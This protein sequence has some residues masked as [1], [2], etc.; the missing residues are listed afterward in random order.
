MKKI[1]VVT[2]SHSGI[3]Q[4]L[5]EEMG[6]TVIP[7]PFYVEDKCYY[8]EISLTRKEFFEK[9]KAGVKVSTSQPAPAEVTDVW[10]KLLKEYETIIYIPISSGLSGGCATAMLLAQEEPYKGKVFVVDNGRASTP[11]QC[12]IIDALELIKE[13]YS[14]AEIK[15]M[16]EKVKADLV[17]YVGLDTLENLK[18]GGRISATSAVL[19][20]ILNIKPIVKFDIGTLDVYKKCRG[21]A[22]AKKEM[23][24][25]LKNDIETRFKEKYEKDEIYILAASSAEAEETEKWIKEIEEAFPGKKVLSGNLPMSLSCHIGYGG[26]GIGCSCKPDRIIK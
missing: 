3:S 9:L 25:A 4:K 14:A 11:Q 6:I 22:K 15:E 16:L 1:G 20:T 8:E 7:M 10:D 23:I 19:G 12:T 2:D 5:A 18:Q 21:F 13:G 26:L 17:I 24:A